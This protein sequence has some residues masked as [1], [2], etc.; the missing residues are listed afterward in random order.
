[1][2]QSA[3]ARFD[4]TLRG[5]VVQPHHPDYDQTRAIYNG[6]IDKRP[7]LIARCANI[8]DVIRAVRFGREPGLDTAI[9]G[10]GHN[11]PGLALVDDGLVID[12]SGLKGLRVDPANRTVRLEPG[13]TW[14]DVDHATHAF[15]LATVSGIIATTEVRA[16]Y[17]PENFFHVNQNIEP[18]V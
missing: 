2:D 9:R 15:G 5:R 10:G 17:D 14:G 18:A 11:G 4:E 13:C 7:R 1:M 12:L 6:M 3:I 8:A 16:R